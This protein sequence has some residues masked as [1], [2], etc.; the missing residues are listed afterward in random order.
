MSGHDF[1]DIGTGGFADTNYPVIIDADYTQ[2]PNQDRETL[3]ENGGRVFYVTT[4]QD[5]NFRVGD[6]F[7]VE[8]ATGRATLSSEEFDL[9]GL[10]ELQLGSITAGKQGATINE[11]S[12]DGTFADNSD[13]SVPTEKATKTY[14]DTEIA[15]AVA[16]SG[17]IQVGTAPNQ[18]KVEVTGSGASTDTIEFDIAGTEV[19]EIGAS[20]LKLPTGNTASR[21]G[22]PVTGMFRYNTTN[23][24]LEVYGS[25][26]WEPAGSLRWEI[27]NSDDSIEKGEAFMVNTQTTAHT[28]TLPGSPALGDYVRIMDY[29]GA[30]STHNITIARNGNNIMGSAAD[31]TIS[32]DNAAIGL[33]YSDATYGWR[34]TEVL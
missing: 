17:T 7:K 14:V 27:V 12:T 15:Q 2:P 22:S 4:D 24:S 10:N 26:S 34:L 31:L 16:G 18:S 23:S 3:S 32:T 28:I 9:A 11:F 8:Q 25:A 13:T 19:A 20:Y 1:L 29:T 33:V 6:Y 21:P 30:A 5:G